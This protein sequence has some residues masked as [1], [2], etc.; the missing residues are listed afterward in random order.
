MTTKRLGYLGPPGTYSEAAALRYDATA[1]L[2]PFSTFSA[3]VSAVTSGMADEGIL[4]FENSLEGP[5]PETLD[6]LTYES[7]LRIR[8]EVMLP[9]EHCLLVR[10][11]TEM[12]D[13]QVIYSHPQALGQCRRFIER[14]FPKARIEAALSTAAAVEQALAQEGAAAISSRRAGEV[15]G[16]AVL[17]S[18]IEDNTANQTRFVVVGA[19]DHPPTGRD[20]TSIAFAVKHDQ[21]GTLV[22]ALHE[23]S[24]RQ[25]NLTRV[26][27]RPLKVG[28][29]QYVFLLDLQGHR[30]DPAVSEA[31]DGVKEQ[32]FFFKIFG[33]YP[34]FTDQ[35]AQ[36]PGAGAS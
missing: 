15:Y 8:A 29:G 28:L 36:E 16:A 2:M 11:G 9:I 22:K 35:T 33:S 23:F 10:P 5:V 32:A 19:T 6:L 1:Q 12:Q 30:S 21:P 34:E 26:E 24:D 27:S 20:K 18:G 7:D 14:C 13:V 4:A 25:I 31:L 17:A 3:I